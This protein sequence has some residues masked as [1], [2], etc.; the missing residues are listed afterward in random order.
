[1]DEHASLPQPDAPPERGG[2]GAISLLWLSFLLLVAYPLSIG[3]AARLHRS[4]PAARPAIETFY[5]PLELLIRSSPPIEKAFEW[6]V[7]VVWRVP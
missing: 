3:P 7:T 5:K 2:S 6:Y 1:M 4:T